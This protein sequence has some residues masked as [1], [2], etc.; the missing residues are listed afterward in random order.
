MPTLKDRGCWW[1]N[2]QNLTETN[3]S[4]L[5][6]THFVSNIRHQHQC[7]PTKLWFQ[8]FCWKVL[9]IEPCQNTFISSFGYV[10][11][12]SFYFLLS[13]SSPDLK[14]IFEGQ[15]NS[16]IMIVDHFFVLHDPA[17]KVLMIGNCLLENCQIF[18]SHLFFQSFELFTIHCSFELIQSSEFD[19]SLRN[20]SFL[21]NRRNYKTSIIIIITCS[22]QNIRSMRPWKPHCQYIID[23]EQYRLLY[24]RIHGPGPRFWSELVRVLRILGKTD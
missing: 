16:K 12:E 23:I 20:V 9:E 4:K 13:I 1:R 17:K 15:K 7:S 6:P 21:R 5:S 22:I 8:W 3:I 11:K 2:G 18:F 19:S 10:W 14:F 24:P